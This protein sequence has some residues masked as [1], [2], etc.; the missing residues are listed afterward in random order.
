[1]MGY[2]RLDIAIQ[3]ADG[4]AAPGYTREE[5]M[6]RF[7]PR[8]LLAPS[9]ALAANFVDAINGCATPSPDG[10]DGMRAIEA[11]EACYRSSQ[12]GARIKL[13]LE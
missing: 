5:I 6:S 13:P 12:S 2:P 10:T 3:R 11:I 7:D 4:S 1:M 9:R 8:D